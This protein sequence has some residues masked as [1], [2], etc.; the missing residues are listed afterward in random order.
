[1]TVSLS[2]MV[3]Y[4]TLLNFKSAGMTQTSLWIQTSWSKKVYLSIIKGIQA[5]FRSFGKCK[6]MEIYIY[7]YILAPK[8]KGYHID[9]L[10]SG[11]FFPE[12]V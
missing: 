3:K 9:M 1:M 7:I 4:I 10:P 12:Y 11:L 5:H 8:D 2:V 6:N